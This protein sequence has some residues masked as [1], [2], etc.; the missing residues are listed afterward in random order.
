MNLTVNWSTDVLDAGRML[1][2]KAVMKPGVVQAEVKRRLAEIGKAAPPK[3]FRAGKVPEAVLRRLHGKRVLAET[4]ADL[5][6]K[7]CECAVAEAAKHHEFD[8]KKVGAPTSARFSEEDGL[9]CEVM[10]TGLSL[11][12][13]APTS[14]GSVVDLRKKES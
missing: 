2:V 4:K 1:L 3:G 7:A 5:V 13:G 6:P 11:A 9:S 8:P 14:S 10:V 12:V